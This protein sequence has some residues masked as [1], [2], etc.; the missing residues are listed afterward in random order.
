[1][2]KSISNSYTGLRGNQQM[3]DVTAN[4]IANLHTVGYKEKQTSF[5]DLT[6]RAL[7]ERRLPHAG[8]PPAPPIS[9]RGVMLGSVT[10]S[11]EQGS[12]I[13]TN[14][15][16]D[17][18]IEGEGFFRV[19]LPDGGYGYTRSGTFSLDGAGSLTMP[20][21]ILLDFPVNL[22]EYENSVDLENIT[23][24]PEG[25]IMA[26]AFPGGTEAD[27]TLLFPGDDEERSNGT[28]EIGQLLLYRFGNPQS[29]SHMGENILVPTEATRP[30][31]EGL[32]G[33]DGFGVLRQGYLEG[34]NVDLS[35]QVT[36]LIRGQRA[37]QAS[38]R[39]LITADELWAITLNLQR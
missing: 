28:I 20:G 3:L 30:F 7:A 11:M 17:L 38:S 32:P 37:L 1:M 33:Q 35:T 36:Q 21:G 8:E 12:L 4:N 27:Q 29:L 19:I 26:S 24:S 18:A 9:G 34:S 10:P 22:L 16:F 13:R 25:R 15:S 2:L 39:S 31:E 5:Q 23:I 14:A 6:Y